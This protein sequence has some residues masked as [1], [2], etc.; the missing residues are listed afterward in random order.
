MIVA[1]ASASAR[2]ASAHNGLTI[3][4]ERQGDGTC[5]YINQARAGGNA[6]HGGCSLSCFADLGGAGSYPS[7]ANRAT[8]FDGE[9][10]IFVDTSGDLPKP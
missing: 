6:P 4:R 7:R 8:A 1:R 9:H 5:L 2:G 3:F 10:A